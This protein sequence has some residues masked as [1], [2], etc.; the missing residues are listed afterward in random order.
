MSLLLWLLCGY[1]WQ[2]ETFAFACVCVCG[3]A[4]IRAIYYYSQVYYSTECQTRKLLQLK[5][6]TNWMIQKTTSSN[7]CE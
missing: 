4:D 1:V 6:S 5:C 3:I 2:N 7:E